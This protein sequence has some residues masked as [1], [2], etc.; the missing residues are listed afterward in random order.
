[1]TDS[2]IFKPTPMKV[3]CCGYEVKDGDLGPVHANPGNGVVQCHNCGHI[4]QPKE[5]ENGNAT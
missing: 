2:R 5:Y 1:M 3:P 4:Y